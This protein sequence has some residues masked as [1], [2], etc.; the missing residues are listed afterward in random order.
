MKENLNLITVISE[1]NPDNPFLP[2]WLPFDKKHLEEY[3][4]KILTNIKLPD[5]SYSYGNRMRGYFGRDQVQDII[6]KLKKESDSR[7]AVI[8]L[9]DANLDHIQK[10]S[11]CLNHLWFRARQEKLYLT[12]VIR[13][14]DPKSE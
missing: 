2:E 8:S 5:I 14:N 10:G 11:P 3:Y 6:D 1:E 9:W 7:S 4:P 12:A 13:S